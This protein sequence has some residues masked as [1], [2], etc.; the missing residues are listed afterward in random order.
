MAVVYF[1]T[2]SSPLSDIKTAKET[3]EQREK[4]GKKPVRANF[5]ISLAADEISRLIRNVMRSG[6]VISR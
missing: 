2:S 6:E 1:P 4:K 5:N 3:G